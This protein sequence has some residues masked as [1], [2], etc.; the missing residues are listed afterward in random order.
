MGG[1]CLWLSFGDT[2]LAG[3]SLVS[4]VTLLHTRKA[5]AVPLVCLT[6]VAAWLKHRGEQALFF[7]FQ[8]WKDGALCGGPRSLPFIFLDFYSM[9]L[10][11][12]SGEEAL[13]G[14]RLGHYRKWQRRLRKR[15][16]G[17]VCF[18]AQIAFT[19]SQ[20]SEK[21]GRLGSA[22][23]RGKNTFFPLSWEG[24]GAYKKRSLTM[25]CELERVKMN[26]INLWLVLCFL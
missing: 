9:P 11:D 7:V 19:V 6:C 25:P 23:D 10:L 2:R 8:T 13:G 5:E 18:V 21:Q 12:R 4:L 20:S 1:S 16:C 14:M 17:P 26:N 15:R 22:M 24:S 3:L